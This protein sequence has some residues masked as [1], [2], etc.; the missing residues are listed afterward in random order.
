MA[1]A[2]LIGA[3]STAFGKKADRTYKALTREAYLGALA[4]AGMDDGAE[5]DLAWFGN[6]T[7]HMDRQANTRG[8]VCMAPLVG[9]GLFP[10]ARPARER[11]ERL[12]HHRERA[13]RRNLRGAGRGFRARTGPGGGEAHRA[14]YRPG[15]LRCLRRHPRSVRPAGVA[16]LLRRGGRRL[17]Q[18][19][20]GGRRPHPLHGHL[21]DA[22]LLPH[23]APRN[24]AAPVCGRG[25]QRPQLRRRQRTRAVP[26]PH[27][28]RRGHGRPRDLLAPD[29]RNV[30]PDGRRSGRAARC[31]RGL[32]ACLPGAGARARSQ[33]P[34]LRAERRQVP[35]AR[36]TGPE[37]RGGAAGLRA[38]RGRPI[39]HRCRGGARRH[40]LLASL[41]VRD[42]GVLPGGRRRA[43]RRI[44]ER[45]G[46][47]ARF[48]SIPRAASS[49]RDIPSAPPAPP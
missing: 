20:R 40:R 30:R 39:R 31:E 46:P 13:R 45:P 6:C 44:G 43:I 26:L 18:A 14:R 22:G 33:D 35:C 48:P 19:L 2:W 47:A 37:L 11:R 27:H 34:R 10:R 41:P 36:R 16:E 3:F 25:G 38:V 42:A 5:I 4:D 21:R 8:Q 28:T 24:H 29:P 1:D 7:M 17:R 23:E 15:P 32:P 12:R 49:R 9:E